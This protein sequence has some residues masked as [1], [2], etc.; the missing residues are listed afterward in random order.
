MAFETRYDVSTH[1][2]SSCPAERLPAIC[3][4]AT[5]AMLVSSTSMNVAS[6]T[7]MAMIQG[8]TA[9]GV[10]AGR[11][12]APPFI[13]VGGAPP[14]ETQPFGVT[15]TPDATPVP[16]SSPAPTQTFTPISSPPL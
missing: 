3:G 15:T 6:V 16:L 12:G 14:R 1:V 13:V 4:N 10:N 5:L 8:L 11:A 2:L 7:A 9:G